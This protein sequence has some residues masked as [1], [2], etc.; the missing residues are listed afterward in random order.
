M[1]KKDCSWQSYFK[2]NMLLNAT[3]HCLFIVINLLMDLINMY[4]Y[5]KG[6]VI[7]VSRVV[8]MVALQ[9][10]NYVL[11]VFKTFSSLSRCLCYSVD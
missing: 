5:S 7:V 1:I 3:Q 11:H 4:Y 2:T 10:N 6:L 9:R 8:V